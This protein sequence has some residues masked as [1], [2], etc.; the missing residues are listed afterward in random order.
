MGIAAAPHDRMMLTASAAR[1]DRIAAI[2]W[3]GRPNVG[4][5]GQDVV[6][7]EAQKQHLDTRGGRSAGDQKCW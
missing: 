2:A 1:S 4:N 6:G 3:L 5:R 7:A